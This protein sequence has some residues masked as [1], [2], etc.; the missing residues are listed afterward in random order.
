MFY[1]LFKK[2][3]PKSKDIIICGQGADGIFGLELHNT[4]FRYEKIIFRLL[5]K[6]PLIQTLK[7]ISQLTGIGKNNIRTLEELRTLDLPLSDIRHLTWSFGAYGSKSWVV[8]NYKTTEEEIFKRR[9]QAIEIFK[10]RSIYDVISLLDII[11]DIA[12]TTSIWSKLSESQKKIIYYPYVDEDIMKYIY[13]IPWNIKLK[14]KKGILREIAYSLEVHRGIIERPKSG[15]GIRPERWATVNGL[16]EPL[17]PLITKYF[18]KDMIRETQSVEESRAMIFWNLLNY[19]IW[20]RLFIENEP[21][22]KLYGELDST[23]AN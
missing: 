5:S 7:I 19:G 22:E 6:Y 2:G 23:L 4:I 11:G 14:K 16:F 9:Y 1:L 13:S 8:R 18:S 21:L 10:N 3:I 12:I 15:F 17:I 20:R